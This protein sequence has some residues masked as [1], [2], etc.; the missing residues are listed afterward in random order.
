MRVLLTGSGGYVGSVARTVLETAGHDVVGL[1]TALYDGCDLGAPPP[2]PELRLDVRDVEPGTSTGFDA[3]VHLAALSND[4]LGELDESSPTR[5]TTR[6]PSA[7]Q[8][9]RAPAASSGSSSRRRAACTAPRAP[10]Q[11]VDET[12]P[13][14]P[15]TAYAESKVRSER[16]LA[17]SPTTTSRP[18]SCASRPPTASRRGC[19]STSCSTTS[20]AGRSPPVRCGCRATARRG[21]R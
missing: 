9:S 15:L 7:S 18:S 17:G 2:P 14:A 12:A 4:P 10:R 8:S 1:D 13:L 20:S 16:S 11:P 21:G 3:V 6:P 5:S 19:A